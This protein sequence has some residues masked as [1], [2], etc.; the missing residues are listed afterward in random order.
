MNGK[1]AAALLDRNI[2]VNEWLAELRDK[3]A[4]H[5]VECGLSPEDGFKH[6]ALHLIDDALFYDWPPDLMVPAQNLA[7]FSDQSVPWWERIADDLNEARIYVDHD[8]GALLALSCLTEIAMCALTD[9][10]G[11]GVLR[12]NPRDNHPQGPR[13]LTPKPS[14]RRRSARPCT[15]KPGRAVFHFG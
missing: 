12:F 7:R 14:D 2:H 3:L 15:P 1:D 5:D 10:Y 4:V 6:V 11:P 13:R 9:K 8:G